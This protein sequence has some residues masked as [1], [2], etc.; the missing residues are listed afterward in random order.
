MVCN[1]LIIIKC[2]GSM[3]TGNQILYTLVFLMVNF[4]HVPCG[5]RRLCQDV[6]ADVVIAVM[7][8]IEVCVAPVC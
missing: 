6:N 2:S 5:W 3:S 4:K 1:S 7:A 8:S